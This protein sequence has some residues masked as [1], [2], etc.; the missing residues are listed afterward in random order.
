MKALLL[1]FL[2]VLTIK[3]CAQEPKTPYIMVLGVAQDGGYPHMDCEK[4]CCKTAWKKPSLSRN[5][6]S[7]ALVDPIA[8]KWWLFEATPDIKQQLQDFRSK[9]SEEYP[10]LPE[11]VFITHAHM[12]HYTGLMEF[13]REVMSTKKLKVYVLPKLK[14]FLEENG[15]WSQLVK[16]NNINLIALEENAPLTIEDSKVTAFRVPH[17]DEF[18]ETA[19]FKIETDTKKY[20]FI[21][22][23]DKWSKWNKSVIDEVK[24]VDIAF[25]DATFYT[26]TELGN[27]AI[28]EVPHPLVSETMD[29]FQKENK[30]V[31]GKIFFIHFNHTNP[32]L[33]DATQQKTVLQKGFNLAVQGKIYF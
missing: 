31:K 11:G 20:L 8:K 2:S 5:V 30:E 29:L 33:R 15:P 9:T 27:R 18:S 32:L 7:L 4:M 17:R 26:N 1:M 6:V 21:P 24:K 16:L 28:T 25:L 12:G 3:L 23:I 19:G 13:G 22:D 10:Y 14:T